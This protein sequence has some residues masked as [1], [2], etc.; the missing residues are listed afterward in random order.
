M[1]IDKLDIQDDMQLSNQII[2]LTP[3]EMDL[4]SGGGPSSDSAMICC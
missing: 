1:P 2:E 4:I 3:E